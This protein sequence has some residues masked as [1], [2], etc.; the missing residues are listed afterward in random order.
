LLLVVGVLAV[1]NKAV[2]VVPVDLE[3]VRGLRL[4]LERLT[5]LQLALV[6]QALHLALV[7]AVRHLPLLAA[8]LHHLLPP[9][10]FLL[11]VE[12]H[13]VEVQAQQAMVDLV[14]VAAGIL[15]ED[16]VTLHQ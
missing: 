7:I 11:V 3:L 8:L 10:L 9:A 13:Q 16:Q 5:Q 2:A 6:V 12:Q 4:L 15:L 1:K 14:A